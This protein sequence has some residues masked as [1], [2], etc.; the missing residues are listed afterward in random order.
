MGLGLQRWWH[1]DTQAEGHGDTSVPC[2]CPAPGVAPLS[3]KVLVWYQN[4]LGLLTLCS[5]LTISHEVRCSLPSCSP[6][7]LLGL[8]SVHFR[9]RGFFWCSFSS[10]CPFFC[11]GKRCSTPS[12]TQNLF[13]IT[14][15]LVTIEFI[16]CL[17]NPQRR[18][19]PL[20]SPRE[21]STESHL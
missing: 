11:T 8:L 15:V 14:P 10:S 16:D 21:T 18:V 9:F 19:S 3:C 17:W 13:H 12:Y 7:L 6:D 2:L 4:P 5:P 1:G 20:K